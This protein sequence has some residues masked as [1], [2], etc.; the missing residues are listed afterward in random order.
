MLTTP[1]EHLP[2]DTASLRYTHKHTDG[3]GQ[4]RIADDTGDDLIETGR[5]W[6]L[7]NNDLIVDCIGD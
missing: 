4:L 6:D 7:P 5:L 3:C 2:A 1:G